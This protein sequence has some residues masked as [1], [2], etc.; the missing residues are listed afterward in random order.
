LQ[1]HPALYPPSG[2]EQ[3]YGNPAAARYRNRGIRHGRLDCV[4][5]VALERDFSGIV[6]MLGM[7]AFA[8]YRLMPALQQ[9][10][11]AVTAVRFYGSALE[12]V[13]NDLESDQE[14]AHP[15]DSESTPSGPV[16]RAACNVEAYGVTSK[17]GTEGDTVFLSQHRPTR[18]RWR[19]A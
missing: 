11:H 4:Y 8:G 13:L 17:A 16:C 5:F 10:F 15:S 19:F 12:G 18:R 3:R 14:V 2:H 7:Y 1:V 9:I 6:P